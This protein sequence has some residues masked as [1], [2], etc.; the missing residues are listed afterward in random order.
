MKNIMLTL[1][2]LCAGTVVIAEDA[3]QETMQVTPGQEFEITLDSNPSTGYG[4]RAKISDDSLLQELDKTYKTT[5]Q[6]AQTPGAG[7][8]DVFTFKALKNGTAS[9]TISYSRPWEGVEPAKVREYTITIGDAKEE[10]SCVNVDAAAYDTELA[11]ALKI[12]EKKLKSAK[13]TAQRNMSKKTK[14]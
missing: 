5:V 12:D 4:W 3:Q 6:A 7:G 13:K 14:K 2:L 8:K 9:I 11:K 10:K 1:S